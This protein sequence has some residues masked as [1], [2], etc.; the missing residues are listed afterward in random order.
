MHLFNHRLLVAVQQTKLIL[1]VVVL[2]QQHKEQKQQ[3]SRIHHKIMEEDLKMAVELKLADKQ[4]LK[5][6]EDL[7]LNKN[8]LKME[9]LML[10][11]ALEEEDEASAY[12]KYLILYRLILKKL[13]L[14]KFR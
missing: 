1:I 14:L 10:E 13:R 4:T 12:T 5:A 9:A 3:V 11:V 7:P 2:L 6:G 8:S